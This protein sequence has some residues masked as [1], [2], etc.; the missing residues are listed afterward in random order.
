MIRAF[1]FDASKWQFGYL[2]LGLIAG[3]SAALDGLC[4][5]LGALLPA[6]TAPSSSL[7]VQA[8]ALLLKEALQNATASLNTSAISFGIQSI[9]ETEPILEFHYTP[10]EFGAAGVKEVDSNTVYRLAS[11]SKLFPVLAI[12]KHEDM[13]LNDPVT[14]YLPE[15]R[16]LNKQAREHSRVWQVDWD[17]ITLGALSSHL[18]APSDCMYC[19]AWVIKITDKDSGLRH[20]YGPY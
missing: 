4:P 13:D 19:L 2:I 17:S 10:P 8:A 15:L 5:P 3:A 16:D 9:H 18:G 1:D 20:F 12:L 14:K 11:T 6:P 7:H